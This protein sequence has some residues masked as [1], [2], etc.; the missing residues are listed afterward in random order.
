VRRTGEQPNL[1]S[2]AG[3]TV[4][5]PRSYL[6]GVGTAR[7]MAMHANLGPA[8]ADEIA[9]SPSRAGSLCLTPL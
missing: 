1:L 3:A 6:V 2:I 4:I 5:L 8:Q 7:D 9:L